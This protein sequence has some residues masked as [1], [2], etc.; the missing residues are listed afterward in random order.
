LFSS[1]CPAAR[2]CTTKTQWRRQQNILASDLIQLAV[3]QN[4]K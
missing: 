3:N 4:N 2:F 1:F